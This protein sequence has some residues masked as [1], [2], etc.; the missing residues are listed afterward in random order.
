LRSL[1]LGKGLESIYL[2]LFAMLAVGT[3][4]FFTKILSATVGAMQALSLNWML[5]PFFLLALTPF[6][7]K[8]G[9]GLRT[10]ELRSLPWLLLAA[11]ALALFFGSLAFYEGLEFGLASI[12]APIGAAHAL[13]TILLSR[14]FLKEQLSASQYAGALLIII[15]VAV[16]AV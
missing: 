3:G 7:S 16:L 9:I 1:R 2:A 8:R 10:R 6:S 12:T 5:T 14:A 15:A 11:T 13:P 4:M